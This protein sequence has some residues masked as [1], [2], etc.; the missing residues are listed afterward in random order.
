MFRTGTEAPVM[1]PVFLR[2]AAGFQL[3]K[4]AIT[5]T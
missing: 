2:Q 3:P 1:S 5:T 4:L